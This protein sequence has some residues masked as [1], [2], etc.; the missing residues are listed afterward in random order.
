[1]RLM[2]CVPEAKG[3]GVYGMPARARQAE[4]ARMDINLRYK[5]VQISSD[6]IQNTYPR[7]MEDQPGDE[8]GKRANFISAKNARI[9]TYRAYACV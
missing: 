5:T 9:F 1:M 3:I 4:H 7:V 2:L 6:L 8:N